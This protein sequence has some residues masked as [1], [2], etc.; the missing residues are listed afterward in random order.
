[1]MN[2]TKRKLILL[3]RLRKDLTSIKCGGREIKEKSLSVFIN[4]KGNFALWN[5]FRA[6]CHWRGSTKKTHVPVHSS[7]LLDTPDPEKGASNSKGMKIMEEQGTDETTQSMDDTSTANNEMLANLKVQVA[8]L[9]VRLNDL[10]FRVEGLRADKKLLM[11]AVNSVT[12]ITD[13]IM[14]KAVMEVVFGQSKLKKQNASSSVRKGEDP[15]ECSPDDVDW[16]KNLQIVE[17]NWDLIKSQK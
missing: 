2:Q 4:K 13:G 3:G 15:K 8:D 17:K 11:H 1:M 6:N 10:E 12:L 14:R 7:Q 9:Q 5:C 16:K